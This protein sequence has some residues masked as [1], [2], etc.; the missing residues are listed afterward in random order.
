MFGIITHIKWTLIMKRFYFAIL[1]VIGAGFLAGCVVP[2]PAPA[3]RQAAFVESEFAPYAGAGTS[4]VTGQAFLKT[5]GGEVRFGAGCEVVMVPVTS[6]TTETH[7]RAV[8]GGERLGPHDSRYATYR[9]TTIAD[10]NGNFE[11]RNV[12]A[13]EY[14]LDC[15]IQWEYPTQYGP[16]PTGG[17]AFGQVRVTSGETVKVV[18]TR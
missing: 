8:M 18:L 16:A 15:V 11:F 6:Y 10:G 7:Q 14:Y 13:G 17:A 4:T 1:S 9:R 12:P 3:K 2:A 5:R